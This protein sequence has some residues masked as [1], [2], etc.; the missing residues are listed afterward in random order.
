MRQVLTVT[1]LAA[2]L[3]GCQSLDMVRSQ[4]AEV[5]DEGLNTSIQFVCNDTS[6]GSIKRRFAV[7]KEAMD[8]WIKFCYG[9]NAILTVPTVEVTEVIQPVPTPEPGPT[10]VVP[11]F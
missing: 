4:A 9:D 7:S 2:L 10:I 8:K 11:D 3:A 5:Y 1:V 6:V